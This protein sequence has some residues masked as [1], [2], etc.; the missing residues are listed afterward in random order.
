MKFHLNDLLVF[1][2]A[3]V[4]EIGKGNYCPPLRQGVIKEPG[5]SVRL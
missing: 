3:S 2:H 5:R 4:L 1:R